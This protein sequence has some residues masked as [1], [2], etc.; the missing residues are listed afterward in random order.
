MG[1]KPVN[2]SNCL[3]LEAAGSM[4]GG[5]A[6]SLLG[7][8]TDLGEPFPAP[9]HAAGQHTGLLQ[10]TRHPPGRQARRAAVGVVAEVFCKFLWAAEFTCRT[11]P[12]T[13]AI[14]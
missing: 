12:S 4:A 11:L 2:V 14:G 10:D 5:D 1:Q 6:D 3:Q 7:D 9:H 8:A 13:T